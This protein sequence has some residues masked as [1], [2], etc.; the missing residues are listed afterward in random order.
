MKGLTKS[1]SLS[2]LAAA[3]YI[4]EGTV[5]Y[6]LHK[7]YKK[8]CVSS[9]QELCALLKTYAPYF[10]LADS[11]LRPAD[12]VWAL[13]FPLQIHRSGAV[14]GAER[15]QRRES[16]NTGPYLRIGGGTG[17]CFVRFSLLPCGEILQALRL[18]AHN[19]AFLKPSFLRGLV[20]VR[21]FLSRPP[22][23]L[24]VPFHLRYLIRVLFMNSNTFVN[25]SPRII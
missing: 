7:I 16:Q 25:I 4:S 17:H 19:I 3:L 22:F 8:T 23:F 14:V 12:R 10:W 15:W 20:F 2:D 11:H 6:H 13:Q 21:F 24:L 18:T 1:M 9:R 5:N